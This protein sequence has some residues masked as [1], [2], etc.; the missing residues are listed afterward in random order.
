MVNWV[1]IFY[2]DAGGFMFEN[3]KVAD[4]GYLAAREFRQNNYEVSEFGEI[5]NREEILERLKGTEE[6]FTSAG[7]NPAKLY[8]KLIN[9]YGVLFCYFNSGIFFSF[10][11][12]AYKHD[13]IIKVIEHTIE[14]IDIAYQNGKLSDARR[15]Y[16]KELMPFV[17][18]L[19]YNRLTDADKFKWF[20]YLYEKCEIVYGFTPNSLL[21]I[22]KHIPQ[23]LLD[24][25]Q[26]E[27]EYIDVFR[28]EQYDTTPHKG[29]IAWT[30]D[31]E[32]AKWFASRFPEWKS[33]LLSGKVRK[34]DTLIIMPTEYQL[35]DEYRLNDDY[36]IPE[37]ILKEKTILVKPGT[38]QDIKKIALK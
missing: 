38:V 12:Y 5:A 7:L 27:G 36:E 17:Y 24:S 29:G 4:I 3:A 32:I 18:K 1:F 2:S 21:E 26:S 22:A 6:V 35:I 34:C 33:K 30:T 11:A 15:F 10:D 9:A 13:N 23:S 28:G 37:I 19:F 8:V 20:V 31:I 25:R 14:E 16:G